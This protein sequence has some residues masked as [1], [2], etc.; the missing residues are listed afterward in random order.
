MH[1]CVLVFKCQNYLVPEDIS[2][3]FVQNSSFHSY[4]AR[5]HDQHL[6]KP[7]NTPGKRT[8]RYSGTVYFNALPDAIKHS[9]RTLKIGLY[10]FNLLFSI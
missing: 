5:R 7:K 10:F 6:S 3:Y 2:R 8:F 4:H 9:L 1:K